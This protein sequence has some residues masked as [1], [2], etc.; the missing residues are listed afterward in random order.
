MF[1][2]RSNRFL[3]IQTVTCRNNDDSVDVINME[4]SKYERNTYRNQQDTLQSIVHEAVNPIRYPSYVIGKCYAYYWLGT[5]IS[6]LPYGL[7]IDTLLR[8]SGQKPR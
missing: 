2:L 8:L 4:G 6:E 1:P 5:M 7:A 3:L